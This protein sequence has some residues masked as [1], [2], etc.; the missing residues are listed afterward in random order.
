MANCWKLARS[1]PP[2]AVQRAMKSST[3]KIGPASF[4]TLKPISGGCSTGCPGGLSGRLPGAFFGFCKHKPFPATHLR[5]PSLLARRS[6]WTE[7][8]AA[9]FE[10]GLREGEERPKSGRVNI[11]HFLPFPLSF[12]PRLLADLEGWQVSGRGSVPGRPGGRPVSWSFD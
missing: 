10:K 4:G 6:P 9:P 7:A 2:E 11:T 1:A 5:T 3:F 8:V 12:K